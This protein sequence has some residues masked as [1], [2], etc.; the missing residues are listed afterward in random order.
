MMKIDVFLVMIVLGVCF[1]AGKSSADDESKQKEL[2]QSSQRMRGV[3][4]TVKANSK[5]KTR[6]KLDAAQVELGRNHGAAMQSSR[7]VTGYLDTRITYLKGGS[8]H[9]DVLLSEGSLSMCIENL[10]IVMEAESSSREMQRLYTHVLADLL[11]LSAW[12]RYANGG[13]SGYLAD[14]NPPRPS[15]PQMNRDKIIAIASLL[16]ET[17][18]F[19][20]AWRAQVEAIY[21]GYSPAW[22]S[23]NRDGTW[24]SEETADHWGRAAEYAHRAGRTE[25]GTNYLLKAAVFGGEKAF[26]KAEK[27]SRKW[28]AVATSETESKAVDEEARRAALT[29][30]VHLYAEINAHPRALQLLDDYPEVFEDAQKLRKEIEEQWIAVVKDASRA[31][32]QVTLYGTQVYPTGDPLKV[33]IPWAF[34]DEAVRSVRDRLK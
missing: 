9:K 13:A 26:E 15:I 8:I 28:S 30:V 29:R 10:M 20:L 31:A 14:I 3:W 22:P 16:E 2:L 1:I 25:L 19:D 24:L 17:G 18:M 21:C 34:S 32:I 6:S 12:R 11:P 27:I 33:R 7:A 4:Q 5:M 23:E